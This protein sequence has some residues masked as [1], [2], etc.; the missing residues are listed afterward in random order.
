MLPAV[1]LFGCVTV[2]P[3]GSPLTVQPGSTPVAS[4][5]PD[6]PWE[7]ELGNVS[8]DGSRS[9]DSALRLFAMAYGPV[10]GVDSV[11]ATDDRLE[12]TLAMRAILRHYDEL[13]ADQK[14]TVDSWLADEPGAPSVVI[15]PAGAGRD[16]NVIAAVGAGVPVR[17][18]VAADELTPLQQ[19][20]VDATRDYRADIAAKL[21]DIPGDIKLS[22]PTKQ[23]PG[24][25]ADANGIWV[26]DEYTG[27]QIRWF[28]AGTG[29][30]TLNILLTA[31]HELFHCFQAANI[32]H[33][34]KYIA[35][36][37]WYQEGG[38]E[39]A[40]YDIVGPPQDGGFWDDYV[41]NPETPLFQRTYD[42][43][44]FW[45]DLAATGIDP[46]SH[47]KAIWSAYESEGAWTASGA[48]A[49]DF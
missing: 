34:Q 17:D 21:G 37:D 47:W 48:E 6:S 31:G 32:G 12:G 9:L 14:T 11:P 45:A 4:R 41:D 22:F 13:T 36:P 15:R 42:G 10:P 16:P 8:P 3:T 29:D 25:L 20:I 38:A 26:N 39:W 23:R 19:A 30:A 1:V 44:G 2:T 33:Q 35:A 43:V 27:C 18:L 5:A 49:D 28:P 24:A 40:S 46:W 7:T